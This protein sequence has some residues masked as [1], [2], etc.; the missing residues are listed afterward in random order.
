MDTRRIPDAEHRAMLV[1]NYFRCNRVDGGRN[2]CVEERGRQDM[3]DGVPRAFLRLIMAAKKRIEV[4][5]CSKT[6]SGDV[7]AR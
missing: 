3:I 1:H 6:S 5:L 7:I 2:G 4:L